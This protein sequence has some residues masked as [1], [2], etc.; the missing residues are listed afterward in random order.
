MHTL[1]IGTDTELRGSIL[2][3]SATFNAGLGTYSLTVTDTGNSQSG[4]ISGS[5]DASNTSVASLGFA[6]FNSGN[7]QNFIFDVPVVV[8]EPVGLSLVGMAV[9]GLMTRRRRTM[10]V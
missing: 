1:A 4:T 2:Q 8:P 9:M 7:G 5:L 10:S 6:N 3:Y